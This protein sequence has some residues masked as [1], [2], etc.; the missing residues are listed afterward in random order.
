MEP[1]FSIKLSEKQLPAPG[2]SV[3]ERSDHRRVLIKIKEYLI[4]SL[5]FYF[6]SVHKL[7]CSQIVTISSEKAIGN[8]KAL[9]T[10]MI[11]NVH[12]L[13]N[14]LIPYFSSE[15]FITKKG[16]DFLD[17]KIICNAI[18]NG[19][20]LKEE[21]KSLILKLSYTMNNYRLSTYSG[22][23]ES[24][25]ED[26]RYLLINATPCIEHL[27][28]GRQR[29]IVT[30]KVIHRRSSSCVYEII[31]PSGVL[32][33]KGN[34]SEAAKII[35]IGFSTLKKRMDVERLEEY[36]IEYKGHKIKRIAVFYPN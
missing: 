17:L 14:Y 12:L 34:L 28:D 7:K 16:Q 35:G 26:A 23:V 25:S 18:Y 13:N 3:I 1:V 11:K 24:F 33:I 4:N 27:S 20:H 19:A 2:P 29:D 22:L 36:P 10:L 15:V 30:K 31:Q 32:S 21:I 9:V 6:Y 8:S 5:D